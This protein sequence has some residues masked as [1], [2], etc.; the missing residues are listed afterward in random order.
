M[1]QRAVGALERNLAATPDTSAAPASIEVP[2]AG[3]ARTREG[4]SDEQAERQ[5]VP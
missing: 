3:Y 1:R 2:S 5:G 4:R